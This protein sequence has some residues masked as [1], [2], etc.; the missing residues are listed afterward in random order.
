MELL[1][2]QVEVVTK[3]TDV[4]SRL[5]GDSMGQGVGK[6]AS[7]IGLDLDLRKRHQKPGTHFRTLIICQK[8][9]LS[10]WY[11]HLRSFGVADNRILVIDPK[12]RTKF[13]KELANGAWNFDYYVC[14]NDVLA[15]LE[16]IN[17]GTVAKPHILWQ[18]VIAD[19]AQLFKNMK[20]A[21]TRELKKLKANVKTALSGTPADN[22]PQ[23]IFSILQWLYPRKYTSY[24]R[25]VEEYMNIDVGYSGYR[26]ILG[27]KLDKIPKL[28]D[29]LEPFYIRRT[30]PDVRESMPPKTYSTIEVELYPKQR[31]MYDEMR[32]WQ[33]A[34]L[35]DS[36]DQELI[37]PYAI[38]VHQRLQQMALGT[39]SLDWSDMEAG[40][41]D[42]PRVK[43]GTPSSKLDA[44][45][46]LVET[47]SDESLVI[48]TQFIGMAD[49][50]EAECKRKG[51]STSK[52]TANVTNQSV[53]DD[54]VAAFQSGES[55]VFVGTIGAAGTTI[56]LN[57]AHTA[58]F[59]DRHWN[60]SKNAQAEDRIYR[61][62]N[63]DTPVQIIDIVARDT[64]DEYR[65][66]AIGTKALWLRQL[67][68]PPS[69]G[70]LDEALRDAFKLLGI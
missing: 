21:R 70:L 50:V 64:I 26:V 25:F 33:I 67:L 56:T 4:R 8:G 27:P 17:K 39:V 48:F 29:E 41:T 12:D 5:V 28:H 57:R 53:R 3:F 59:M 52:I 47:N 19:E 34:R 65:L 23:D 1:P 32:D 66:A 62:D 40:K 42:G 49:L 45:M 61:I 36:D 11:R 14:H 38:S 16:D 9:G 51:I 20:A 22:K 63:D 55:R 30:L 31:K 37:A 6:T 43:I 46:E 13:E 15:K 69:Y 35:G 68:T 54:A 58:I 2:H 18:H 24:W 10:V 7:G 60:P 44:V